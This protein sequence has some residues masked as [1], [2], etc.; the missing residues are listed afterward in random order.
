MGTCSHVSSGDTRCAHLALRMGVVS[1]RRRNVPSVRLEA[2]FS[3]IEL[4]FVSAI[5]TVLI[6][7]VVLQIDVSRPVLKGDGAMRV[8]LS[9]MRTARE[10]AIAQRRYMR[11]TFTAPGQVAILREEVPGPATTTISTTMLEGGVEFMLP[12]VRDTDDGFGNRT[13]I[14]FGS[15]VNIKFSPDGTLVNQ[16][17]Q[18]VNGTVFLGILNEQLSA[19]A[20]TVMGATGRLR[21]YRWNG[22][23][24]SV[25]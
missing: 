22:I 5:M 20:V 12:G 3:L 19:R 25:V 1:N 8:I 4:V 18:T 7:M 6:G 9:Q 17:G 14:D 13:E 24:W 10:L 15:A 2:G 23:K 11:I 21:G 16:D